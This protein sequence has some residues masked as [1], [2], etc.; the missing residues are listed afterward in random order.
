[1]KIEQMTGNMLAF[2]G[3]AILSL[4]VRTY[5][6]K[7]GINQAKVLQKMSV[8]FVCAKT[9]AQF[10]FYLLEQSYLTETE[11]TIYRRGRNF[12]VESRPKNTDVVTY[13]QA[14]GLEA[15]WGYWYLTD[16]QT[17]LAE[18]FTLLVEFVENF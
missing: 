17:R 8:E 15:L 4:Q 5:L 12:K 18:L 9:Q 1:M 13:R 6:V 3:D 7:Q 2:V 11:L 14:S 10:M 16:N